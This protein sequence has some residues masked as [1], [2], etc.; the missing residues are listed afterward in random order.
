MLTLSGR[1]ALLGT[2][3]AFEV[4]ARAKALR[5]ARGARSSISASASPTSRRPPISSRPGARRSPTGITATRRPTAS[6]RCARRSPPTSTAATASTVSP[7]QV[8]IVPGGKVTM[9][10]AIMMFGEPGAEII[11]PN[12][13]FPIYESVIR[14]SGATPVPMPLYEADGLLLQRRRGAGEDHA[15]GRGSS[16]STAR[17]TRPAAR[18]PRASSTS[19][20][21][22]SSAHPHVA[23]MSD[24]IYGEMIYDGAE[25]VSLLDLPVARATAS[26]CSTAGARPTR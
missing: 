6:C 5:G 16:S 23:I 9:F 13:G 22:G 10:F 4:L 25:H 20:S 26:S 1:M 18:C 7:D 12:P 14:F 19:S 11:Y 15:A 17:P 21:P 24:E 3:S 2:E 8:L